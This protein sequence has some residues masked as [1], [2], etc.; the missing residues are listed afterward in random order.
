MCSVLLV[1]FQIFISLIFFHKFQL[2][3]TRHKLRFHPSV[4]ML[5]MIYISRFEA[6]RGDSLKY[7]CEVIP[8]SEYTKLISHEFKYLY[9]H[10]YA[11]VNI[12]LSIFP[13]I[14]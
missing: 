13:C 2:I 1:F 5:L 9:L 11:A 8:I 4:A 6:I 7:I 14:L 12:Y 3:I 10:D